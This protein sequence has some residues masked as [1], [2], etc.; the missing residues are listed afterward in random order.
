MTEYIVE[1]RKFGKFY[2]AVAFA[3]SEAERLNRSIEIKCD[4]SNDVTKV[5]RRWVA[6]MHPPGFQRVSAVESAA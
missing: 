6:R 2:E 4:I 1:G 5:E 3:Q